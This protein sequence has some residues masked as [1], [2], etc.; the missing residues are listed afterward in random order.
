MV[1]SSLCSTFFSPPTTHSGE[2]QLPAFPHTYQG[3]S[4][5]GALL[6]EVLRRILRSRSD[7]LRLPRKQVTF[8]SASNYQIDQRWKRALPHYPVTGHEKW[9]VCGRYTTMFMATV[10]R[11][12]DSKQAVFK[13]DAVTMG[14]HVW[15]V[16]DT[17]V[18]YMPLYAVGLI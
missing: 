1:D 2:L 9:T 15:R 10:R 11:A 13:I 18:H 4:F 17:Y 16:V 6:V 5:E 14:P 8:K 12:L 7:T 3:K